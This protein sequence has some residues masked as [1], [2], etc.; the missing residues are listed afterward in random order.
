M[1]VALSSLAH[2]K[3]DA[4]IM[5]FIFA[6][7]LGF[8]LVILI[9]VS[10]LSRDFPLYDQ[11]FYFFF[12][13]SLFSCLK[14]CLKMTFRFVNSWLLILENKFQKDIQIKCFCATL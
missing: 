10:S 9:T 11:A 6:L 7:L 3:V 4:E 14:F 12:K 13:T 2:S 8:V 5:F 1:E